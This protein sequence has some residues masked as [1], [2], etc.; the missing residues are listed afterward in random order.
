MEVIKP[1]D[2]EEEASP[3]R[4][5]EL[6]P[7]KTQAS[8]L[9]HVDKYKR[10]L[11]LALD[12]IF[13]LEEDNADLSTISE[14]ICLRL[15]ERTEVGGA[16]GYLASCFKR[17]MQKSS[18][19]SDQRLKEDLDLCK[20]QIVS[21][22]V[23][24]LTTTDM[25]GDNSSQS[26]TDFLRFISSERSSVSNQLLKEIADELVEQASFDEVK[27]CVRCSAPDQRVSGRAQYHIYLF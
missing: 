4:P 10:K 8:P 2:V 26:I 9:A 3:S 17:L 20:K 21:F 13:L 18:T 12:Q 25:F 5:T 19:S 11:G 7:L 6:Q 23:S 14:V 22:I 16:V 24:S 27:R 15:T 1:I